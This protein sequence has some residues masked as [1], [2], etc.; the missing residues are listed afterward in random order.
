MAVCS[1]VR[2]QRYEAGQYPP[3]ERLALW[4]K[5]PPLTRVVLSCVASRTYARLYS[6]LK[7]TD[8]PISRL[9][10]VDVNCVKSTIGQLEVRVYIDPVALIPMRVR[11]HYEPV[12]SV[13]E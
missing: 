1:R 8:Q 10:A 2:P 9:I 3:R 11:P 4:R 7:S 13:S 12:L 5:G 6:F